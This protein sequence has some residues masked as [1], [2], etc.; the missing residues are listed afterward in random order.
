MSLFLRA[1]FLA[2]VVAAVG[3]ASST[4]AKN[5]NGA[6]KQGKV[7]TIIEHPDTDVTT[8]TGAPGD[9]VGDILTFANAVFDSKDQNQ[10]GTDQG[11]CVRTAVGKSYDCQWTTI[12]KRGQLMVQGPFFD[13]KGS[14]LAI[15]GGTGRYANA[16]GYMVL[17]ALEGGK[18]R[19][20]FHIRG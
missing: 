10:V 8:D 12:L 1:A 14:E 17:E 4:V 6:R 7:I 2:M 16:R 5:D 13:T 15:T 19:F 9:S 20:E 3:V 11:F 18:F